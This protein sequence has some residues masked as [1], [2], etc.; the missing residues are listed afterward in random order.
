MKKQRRQAANPPGS[1]SED[2]NSSQIVVVN[3]ESDT[4]ASN[5]ATATQ[6]LVRVT[7]SNRD[8]SENNRPKKKAKTSEHPVIRQLTF[9]N[10]V[11]ENERQVVIPGPLSSTAS[12]GWPISAGPS[13]VSGSSSRRG[14]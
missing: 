6:E 4:E 2:S 12:T 9:N 3:L 8:S 7:M 13:G 5:P 11:E 1:E 10:L 14:R